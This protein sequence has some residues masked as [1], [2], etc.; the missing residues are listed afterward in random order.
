VTKEEP[1]ALT[2]MP[3][4]SS[5]YEVREYLREGK[6][7]KNSSPLMFE[8]LRHFQRTRAVVAAAFAAA[9]GPNYSPSRPRKT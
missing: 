9:G 5:V 2:S 3:E 7:N 1:A 8:V 4:F 6:R